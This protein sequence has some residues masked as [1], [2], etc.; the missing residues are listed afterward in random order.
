MR[1]TVRS[2][3]ADP[4]GLVLE[5]FEALAGLMSDCGTDSLGACSFL[6]HY[7][8]EE[9]TG[10]PERVRRSVLA[11]GDPLDVA[12]VREGET[13]LDVGCGAGLDCFLAGRATGDSGRVIGIDMS[14]AMLALARRN[15]HDVTS[16]NVSFC[17]AHMEKVPLI[18]G[19]VD[20]VI[21]N[22]SINLSPT[23]DRVFKEL[24]RVL[25]PGGRFVICDMVLDGSFPDDVKDRI[26][27]WAG[28][29]NGAISEQAYVDN[30]HVAGFSCVVVESRMSYG[31]DRP[32]TLD[33]F[34][35]DY[36][37][38]GW[39]WSSVSSSEGLF[40]IRITG[41]RPAGAA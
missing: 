40:A 3:A 30:L 38:G 15:A 2:R 6:G 12:D 26:F 5:Q 7:R 9:L 21:S 13:I 31:L 17:Q 18:D 37:L 33:A 28:C 1:V 8:P 24:F 39:E 4:R 27:A 14:P 11:C 25:R 32:D 41:R 16:S 23:K 36:L 20:L 10:I 22:S 35:R 34:S 19:S 29:V